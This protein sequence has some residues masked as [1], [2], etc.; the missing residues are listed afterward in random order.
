MHARLFLAAPVVPVDVPV[1]LHGLRAEVHGVA[2]E[3]EVVLGRHGQGVPHERAGVH[4]ERRGHLAGYPVATSDESARSVFV[5]CILGAQRA[6]RVG[7]V[8]R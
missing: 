3:E 8:G 2:G 4:N 1:A 7:E 6:Q 5:R